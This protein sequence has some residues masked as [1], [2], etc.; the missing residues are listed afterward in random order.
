[1]SIP[2]VLIV[3]DEPEQLANIKNYLELR[4]KC[5]FA[6]ASNGDEAIKYIK[7]KPC[8]VMILDIRMPKK[9]G[10]EV[11]DVA[12]ELPIYTIVFTGWDSDQVFDACKARGA[13]DYIQ[14]GSSLKVLHDK[15][16][17]A[18]KE[19]GKHHPLI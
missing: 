13:R 19:M 4:I 18:L 5:N 9:T 3:D 8:D 14:K 12:K 7:D 16:A 17:K 1:M 10:I 2:T 11:L 15:V 6:D